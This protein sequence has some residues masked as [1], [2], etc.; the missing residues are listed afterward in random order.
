M[1]LHFDT[2]AL[3]ARARN[4]G[5]LNGFKL[6]FVTLDAAPKPDFAL[7]D[8]EFHNSNH[9][10]PLPAKTDFSLT[11]G[12]R[13]RA[14]IGPGQVQITT[15]SAGASPNMLRL[16]VEPIG[17]YSTYTLSINRPEFDPLFSRITFKFRPGCFNLNCAP[18]V[19]GLAATAG[20][21][22]DRLSRP[23]L[24]FV[25]SRAHRRNDAARA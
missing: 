15:V 25:P 18:D 12:T 11:G 13:V 5:A 1:T 23:R 21:A 3:A 9:L 10:A 17:D 2:E 24:H 7:L 20:R 6:V 14:G 19:G 16:R 4:L 22:G 8:V